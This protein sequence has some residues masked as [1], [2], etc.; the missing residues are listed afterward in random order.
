MSKSI[1]LIRVSTEQQ[2]LAQQTEKVKAEAIKDGF[3]ES[4]I[5]ILEDKESAVKLSEEERNGLNKLKWHIEHDDISCVYAYEISRISRQPSTLYS[6]RDYLIKHHVQLI[7]L[8]PYMKM[9]N[10]D[11][12]LSS[13]ANIF[14]GIFSSMAENEGY[15]R[16]A[17]M[18]RGRAKAKSLGR[19]TGGQVPIGY[20]INKDKKYVI[21]E[22]GAE[23]VRRIFN[24][25]ISGVSI[26]TIVKTLQK[27]GWRRN[28][29][30]HTLTNSVFKI[31]HREYYCGDNAHPQIISREIFDAAD[32]KC[33]DARVYIKNPNN[34]ALL[35]GLL[36]DKE[37]NHLMS[38]KYTTNQYICKR[39]GNVSISIDFID[40]IVC[41]VAREWY[42]IIYV[43]KADEF[44]EQIKGQI[45]TQDNI[46]K[47]MEQNITDN[48]DKIDRIEERYIMGKINKEKADYLEKDTW[49]KMNYYKA[50]LGEAKLKK[51]ELENKLREDKTKTD[52]IREILNDV[53]EDIKLSR[54]SKHIAIIE[55]R[56]KYTGE[57]RTIKANTLR[58]EILNIDIK[59]IPTLQPPK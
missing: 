36:R 10:D 38:A 6:I 16:K 26:R 33:K 31:L 55:I 58:K 45:A 30:E 34:N 41:G 59:T 25:Y 50:T 46:I 35:K 9:L 19:H 48:Q 27:E 8:N 4:N 53:V 24:D 39:Y 22:E 28:T 23:I 3:T 13:T 47:T 14:F 32:N 20:S 49:D 54:Q 40:M 1:L 11:G 17:R 56:N 43:V 37:T 2:D 44:R 51:Q 12:T 21:D 18:A 5:I 42:N 7:I 15:I 52:S 29:S 57:L